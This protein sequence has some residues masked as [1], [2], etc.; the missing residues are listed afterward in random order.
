[1]PPLN[2]A[3]YSAID[4][5][6][7]NGG[8]ESALIGLVAALGRAGDKD[9]RYTII[10]SAADPDWLR[11]Y[12]GDNQQLITRPG[13]YS[14]RSK[15]KARLRS[16]FA[17]REQRGATSTR[18][19][20]ALGCDVIHFPYQYFERTAL[21]SIYTPHDLQHVHHPE[22]FS[23]EEVARREKVYREGC[24]QASAITVG[25]EWVK[26]DLVESYQVPD[27]KIFIVPWAP[28]TEVYPRL[29]EAAE[30]S[31]LE[32]L[33]LRRPFALYPAVTW[34]HKNH[35][36][37]LEALALLRD[38][39]TELSL[40][41][42]GHQTPYFSEIVEKCRSLRLSNQV[43]FLGMVPGEELRALYRNAEL[44]V[45][46]TLF[47]AA[48]GPMFEAWLE[49]TPVACSA[50]TSLPEQANGAALLFDPLSVE[51]IAQALSK[52]HLDERLRR[53]LVV[54]G[55]RRLQDFDWGRTAKS[56]HDI[57]QAVADG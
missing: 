10:V 22:F 53:G 11:P 6:G 43:R 47:E 17:S 32:R 5:V 41:C 30:R 49:E 13:R 20:D 27:E 29:G 8:L 44:V 46:P 31:V 40:V 9:Q 12:L 34:P 2:V 45:I 14:L 3:I 36:R 56:Y 48:S 39:G 25:S 52:L 7:R 51:E 18:F 23:S 24:A 1:M 16:S 4:D 35:I 42:T 38:E 26:Q 33:G 15:I 28:V 57:Y 55:S 19:L 54:K 37:L 50:V 21:P